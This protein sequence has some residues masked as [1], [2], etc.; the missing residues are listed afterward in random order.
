MVALLGHAYGASGKR[1]E[2]LRTLDQLKE[3]SEQRY[4]SAYAF[5]ILYAGL[6][7]KDQALQ[8]LEQAYQ[9]HDWMIARLKID[10]LLESLRSDPRFTDLVRRVG[11]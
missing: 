1:D 3:I 10:P 6:G 2:A 4:V 7:E 11:L 8:S 9:N 5:A